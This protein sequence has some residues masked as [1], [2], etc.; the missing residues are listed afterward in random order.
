MPGVHRYVLMGPQSKLNMDDV[1]LHGYD[2]TGQCSPG[3]GDRLPDRDASHLPT[4]ANRGAK[5]Q[6]GALVLIRSQTSLIVAQDQHSSF[7]TCNIDACLSKMDNHTR[8]LI[9]TNFDHGYGQ[10]ATYQPQCQPHELNNTHHH[11]HAVHGETYLNPNSLP[12][13]LLNTSFDGHTSTGAYTYGESVPNS[14]ASGF[15]TASSLG[16]PSPRD[17]SPGSSSLHTAS[18]T[19]DPKA[20]KAQ[21]SNTQ[22]TEPPKKKKKNKDRVALAVDQ[23]LTSQGKERQRVYLACVQW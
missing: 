10:P 6:T 5:R 20:E 11:H 19:A 15:S 17:P 23:P 4:I 21:V 22:V 12:T 14:A 1:T 16:L 2:W 13:T 9:S 3:L 7:P 8:P 18:P